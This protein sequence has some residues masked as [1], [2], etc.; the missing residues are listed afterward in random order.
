MADDRQEIVDRFY[1]TNG[2]CCAGCD[3]WRSINVRI[4][5]CTRSAPV[6][7]DE[8]L[9][10]IGVEWSSLRLGPGHVLTPVSHTSRPSRARTCSRS[11]CLNVSAGCARIGCQ[12]RHPASSISHPYSR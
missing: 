11:A 10:V 6:S 3:W 8:R 4:G 12:S 2:A 1:F 7:A 9:A 5:E